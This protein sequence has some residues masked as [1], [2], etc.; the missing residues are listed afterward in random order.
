M[1]NT[2]LI[3]LVSLPLLAAAPAA[4]DPG[5]PPGA[6]DCAVPVVVVAAPPALPRWGVSLRV[7]GIGLH[8]ENEP[9]N[10]TSYSGGGLELSYRLRPR[11]VLAAVVEGGA[12]ERDDGERGDRA[13]SLLTL[14]AQF[15]PWPYARWDFYASA[16]LGS[17]A[18]VDDATDTVQ[19]GGAVAVGVGIERHIG[20]W[21][22]GAELRAIGAGFDDPEP[23]EDHAD[24][25]R[26]TT[27]DDEDGQGMS[28]GALSLAASYHF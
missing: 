13:L 15:H 25:A 22:L 27:P 18:I 17:A 28:G 20:H 19:H 14:N 8:P 12:E 24:A 10:Q 7:G 3:P 6:C 11:W 5:G 23:L 21:G 2:L 9:D 16:G 26:M 1:R 4:A